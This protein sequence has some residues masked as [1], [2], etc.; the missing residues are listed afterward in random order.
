[1]RGTNQTNLEVCHMSSI[2]SYKLIIIRKEILRKRSLNQTN[3]EASL[4]RSVSQNI[5]NGFTHAQY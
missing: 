3:L 1:M 4:M 5:Q 2:N